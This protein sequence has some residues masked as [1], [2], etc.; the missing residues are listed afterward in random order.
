MT[1]GVRI[2]GEDC[3]WTSRSSRLEEAV[4]GM[5][6]RV[7]PGTWPRTSSVLGEFHS[8]PRD[9]IAPERLL[10]NATCFRWCL[11]GPQW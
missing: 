1:C 2:S 6:G 4:I 3:T 8:L 9:C 11:C 10:R 5:E 7:E